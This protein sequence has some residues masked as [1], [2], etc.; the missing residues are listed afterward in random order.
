MVC[1]L[2]FAIAFQDLRSLFPLCARLRFGCIFFSDTSA[3]VL[4]NFDLLFQ[5]FN[6]PQE[7]IHVNF[8]VL[9]GHVAQSHLYRLN[10]GDGE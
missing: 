4:Q 10:R 7:R 5:L 3:T 9:G 6:A 1:L 8:L 2:Q